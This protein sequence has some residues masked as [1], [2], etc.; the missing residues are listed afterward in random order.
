MY[1]R[2]KSIPTLESVIMND[3]KSAL[4]HEKLLQILDHQVNFIHFD[5]I[6]KQFY[7]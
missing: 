5:D 3:E 2:D 7:R 4:E 1:C 6:L